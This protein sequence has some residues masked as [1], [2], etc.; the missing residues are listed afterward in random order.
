V[1]GPDWVLNLPRSGRG[2]MEFLFSVDRNPGG[3][4]DGTIMIDAFAVKLSQDAGR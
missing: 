4:R 3:A 1:S 2:S